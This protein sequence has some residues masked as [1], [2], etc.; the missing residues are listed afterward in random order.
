MLQPLAPPHIPSLRSPHWPAAASRLRPSH[1][2]DAWSADRE[3]ALDH[4]LAAVNAQV[5][6]VPI[7][8]ASPRGRPRRSA[9]TPVEQR[10]RCPPGFRACAAMRHRKRPVVSDRTLCAYPNPGAS[11]QVSTQKEEPR[12]IHRGSRLGAWV[13]NRRSVG[14]GDLVVLQSPVFCDQPHADCGHDVLG[15]DVVVVGVAFHA[16]DAACARE[17]Q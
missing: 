15:R 16:G 9:K 5:T 14:P 2:A 10:Q 11:S 13:S 1:A 12:R 4:E 17:Q 8:V 3:A 7:C 6:P